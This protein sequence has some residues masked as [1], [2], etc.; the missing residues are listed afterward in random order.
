MEMVATAPLV[1]TVIQTMIGDN[2]VVYVVSPSVT[3]AQLCQDR[4]VTGVAGSGVVEVLGSGLFLELTTVE[5]VAEARGITVVYVVITSLAKVEV[6]MVVTILVSVEVA[7]PVVPV[8][9]DDA[10]VMVV[11]VVVVVVVVVVCFEVVVVLLAGS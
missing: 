7:V 5:V 3:V 1:V 9:E 8:V 2:F 4:V 6:I 10:E 11:G